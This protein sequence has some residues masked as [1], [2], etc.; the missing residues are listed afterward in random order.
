VF[1]VAT[2]IHHKY[3]QTNQYE[4]YRRL[5]GN[6]TFRYCTAYVY[7]DSNE[8]HVWAEFD[9]G[10]GDYFKTHV[11]GSR[12]IEAQIITTKEPGLTMFGHETIS[13]VFPID[14]FNQAQFGRYHIITNNCRS[15][16][17][18]LHRI[19]ESFPHHNKKYNKEPVTELLNVNIGV[20]YA[21]IMSELTFKK[22][23][24]AIA[25]VS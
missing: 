24:Q 21:N 25:S 23:Q 3:N 20:D 2:Y 1:A 18:L 9:C 19:L 14:I 15:Y 10:A 7:K 16:L 17:V 13:G 6:H 22:I 8:F 12:K 11:F 4:N 5:N